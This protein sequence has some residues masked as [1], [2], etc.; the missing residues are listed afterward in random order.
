MDAKVAAAAAIKQ[1]AR[2]FLAQSLLVACLHEMHCCVGQ[3]FQ[4][5]SLGF[6]VVGICCVLL[7]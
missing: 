4:V 7:Y 5:L 2:H 6:H 3:P 1:P